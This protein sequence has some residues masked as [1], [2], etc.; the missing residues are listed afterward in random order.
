MEQ[1]CLEEITEILKKYNCSLTVDFV[2]DKVMSADVL[3]YK[4]VIRSNG[5]STGVNQE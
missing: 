5:N 3:V 1:K 4:I 2:K